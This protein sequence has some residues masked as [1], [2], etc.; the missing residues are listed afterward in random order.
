[1]ILV[2]PR[3]STLSSVRIVDDSRSL[4]HV[5]LH[6]TDEEAARLLGE[7]ADI[8]HDLAE[9]GLPVSHSF[10]NDGQTEVTVFVYATN[11]E[12][13]SEVETRLADDA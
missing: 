5:E 4:E 12:L 11:E 3:R 9:V 10:I 2:L 1:M 7:V 6:L 8:R 13:E